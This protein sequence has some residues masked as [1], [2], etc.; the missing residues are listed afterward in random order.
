MVS[1]GVRRFQGFETGVGFH[2]TR[3][4]KRPVGCHMAMIGRASDSTVTDGTAGV[5]PNVTV[6]VG[7]SRS[8][9]GPYDTR[10]RSRYSR[11]GFWWGKKTFILVMRMM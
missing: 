11:R 7:V 5:F 9:A 10:K 4:K 1:D 2:V 8:L 6:L 3:D